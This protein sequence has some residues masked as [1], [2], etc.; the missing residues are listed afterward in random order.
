MQK[1][2][3][4]EEMRHFDDKTIKEKGVSAISL[5]ENAAKAALRTLKASFDTAKVLFLCGSGNNGGDGFAMARFFAE[6]SGQ[7]E[8]CY[9]GKMKDG[10]PDESAMSPAC[11][12]EYTLLPNHIKVSGTPSLNGVSAV[13]DAVFGTGLC[14]DI[15]GHIADA[16]SRVRESGIPVLAVDIPSGIDANTG[17]VL[18]AVLPATATVAIE[19]EKLGHL[20]YPGTML[21]GRVE[22][23]RIGIDIG[24]TRVQLLERNDVSLLPQR[25]ARAH[26][27]S[28][29]RVLIV[30]G[31]P[32]MSGA[33]HLAAKAAYRA[34]AGLVEMLVP[35]ENRTVHQILL[36][37]AI[38][39]AYGKNTAVECLEKA[40]SRADAVAI[41]MGL[42]CS[43]TAAA[44]VEGALKDS[45]KPILFDADALNLIA[46]RQ[47]LLAL[48]YARHAPTVLTPHLAEMSRLSGRSVSAIAANM[49]DSATD[50]ANATRATVVLK[51]ARTVIAGTTRA[52]LNTFGNNGMATGGSGDTLAG[53]IAAFLASKA[54]IDIAAAVGVLTH[55]LAGDAA[56]EAHGTHGLMASDIIEALCRV[57][58]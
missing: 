27:G 34:G 36:P 20:L 22:V 35:E 51:D 40:L 16:L 57:L 37:E 23:A 4:R 31:S 45:E 54:P 41:G 24:E 44:L 26:K 33:A 42:S 49:L 5:M 43:D 18:G 25:P 21:C 6:E 2:T 29:G 10:K 53:I 17:A 19:A 15:T 3:T 14:R 47:E 11:A 28:F 8:I 7:C 32:E 12:T 9:L 46:A 38:V 1:I 48:L 13:V 50:Y 39:T 58:P 55:A 30:G 52:Y 56:M